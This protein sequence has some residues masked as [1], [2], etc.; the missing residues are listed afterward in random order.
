MF[1]GAA[2]VMGVA[3]CGK[4]SVGQAL[5]QVL[6]A[7]FIE[8]DSLHPKENI[9]KMSAGIPLDDDDRWPW[10]ALVGVQLQGQDARIVSCSALKRAYRQHISAHAKRPVSFV[11]LE[12]NHEQLEQH[13]AARKGHF[14][15]P[16]L[17]SS[18]LAALERPAKDEHAQAFNIAGTVDEIVAAAST[19]LLRYQ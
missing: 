19:W 13:I 8:G 17:L 5:A 6:D 15:P 16:S 12:G 14:M 9:D 1:G 18:Q 7:T 4:T 10:L 2:V 3:G 11:F